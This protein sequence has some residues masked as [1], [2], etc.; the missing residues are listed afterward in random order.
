MSSEA[1]SSHILKRS[2]VQISF[3]P[4]IGFTELGIHRITEFAELG[5]RAHALIVLRSQQ[6]ARGFFV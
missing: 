6:V 2:K 5:I 4:K 1:F 3:F